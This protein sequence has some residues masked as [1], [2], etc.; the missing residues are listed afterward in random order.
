MAR[1]FDGSNDKVD[2][3]D[4]GALDTA[5]NM[6][7]MLW[8]EPDTL[9]VS[10]VAICK[11]QASNNRWLMQL[12]DT[13]LGGNDDVNVVL[14]N[15]GNTYGYTTGDIIA[16]DVR[17]NWI[18]Y[19]NG[20]GA[21]NAARLRFYFNGVSQSLTYNGTMPTILN[22]STTNS[23]LVGIFEGDV[24]P[25]DGTIACVCIWEASLSQNEITA[26]NNGI[27]PF[28]IRPDTLQINSPL[29]GNESPEPNY[30]NTIA[31]TVTEAARATPNPPFELMENY[32]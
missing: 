12:S 13:G 10:E 6:T 26:L 8:F 18:M 1:D 22:L 9:A 11:V 28:A 24:V 32:L 19:F 5:S 23:V 14:E 20:G 29:W 27:N 16:T 31:G 21:D 30:A 15:G 25:I 2:F 3:G 7:I 17:N 4:I